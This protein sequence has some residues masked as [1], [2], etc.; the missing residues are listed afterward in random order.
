MEA[1]CGAAGALAGSLE[2][3]AIPRGSQGRLAQQD[4][5]TTPK[6]KHVLFFSA[7]R[8]QY[9]VLSVGSRERLT[10]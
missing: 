8:S 10:T 9:M 6:V 2:T 4:G 5:Y 3:L 7:S 1:R